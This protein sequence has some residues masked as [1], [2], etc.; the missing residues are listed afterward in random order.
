MDPRK[1]KT[2]GET[3]KWWSDEL[4]NWL[5]AFRPCLFVLY[6]RSRLITQLCTPR[7]CS[8]FNLTVA[9]NWK[10]WR[11]RTGSWCKFLPRNTRSGLYWDD[12]VCTNQ[13]MRGKFHSGMGLAGHLFVFGFQSV[14]KCYSICG[15]PTLTHV[16]LSWPWFFVEPPG[17]QIL[18]QGWIP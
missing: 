10:V 6:L 17:D 9:A 12:T 13:T 5:G 1:P 18:R 8:F 15:H 4:K 2:N 11:T 16:K 14:I 7:R 3:Q